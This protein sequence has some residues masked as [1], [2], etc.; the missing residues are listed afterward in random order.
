MSTQKNI[1]PVCL[2]QNVIYEFRNQRMCQNWSDD[3][4]RHSIP[5]PGIL[6][7]V[8]KSLEIYL[9]E[10]KEGTY[11]CTFPYSYYSG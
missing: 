11:F 3:C 2:L 4:S 6:D 10:Y 9:G 8:G 7:C 5:E 1:V